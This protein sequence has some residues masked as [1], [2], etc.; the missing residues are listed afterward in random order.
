MLV[1]E[2]ETGGD[3][4]AVASAVCFSGETDSITDDTASWSPSTMGRKYSCSQLVATTD[5]KP[6]SSNTPK[7]LRPGPAPTAQGAPRRPGHYNPA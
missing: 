7:T 6:A 3:E 4:M 5:V 2:L 1:G